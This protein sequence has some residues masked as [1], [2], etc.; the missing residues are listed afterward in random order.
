[1]KI[2]NKTT[3]IL[4]LLCFLLSCSL[5]E[6]SQRTILT[7]KTTIQYS[8]FKNPNAI[9]ANNQYLYISS[10]QET[11]M[12]DKTNHL[13]IDRLPIVL[14]HIDGDY[15]YS[16]NAQVY[17]SKGQFI[18]SLPG[19]SSNANFYIL[20][21]EQ[22]IYLANKTSN[23]KLA[24]SAFSKG[25]RIFRDKTEQINFSVSIQNISLNKNNLY[26]TQLE[27]ANPISVLQFY[28]F[29]LFTVLIFESSIKLVTSSEKYIY[30]YDG[31]KLKILNALDRTTHKKIYFIKE[32]KELLAD[33]NYLY[34]RTDKSVQIWDKR[35][36]QKISTEYGDIKAMQVDQDHLYIAQDSN[37][38]IIPK[39]HFKQIDY[40]KLSQFQNEISQINE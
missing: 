25:D 37:L 23:S 40:K 8:Q 1:M 28:N 31:I 7:K 20:S 17:S 27:D 36:E 33:N 30:L 4:V 32:A 29:D 10:D 3:S 21:T 38:T 12:F 13:L 15:L 9:F 34:V 14:A 19:A 11:L 35:A 24:I 16:N 2:L 18:E 6:T 26:I 22:K 5:E 39:S